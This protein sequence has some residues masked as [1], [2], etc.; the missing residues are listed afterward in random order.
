MKQE[1]IFS[2]VGVI[3]ILIG[4][5]LIGL[6]FFYIATYDKV[7]GIIDVRKSGPNNR[8]HARITYEYN[9]VLY[10]DIGLSSYN[11]FTMKDGK[12][13]SVY[14]N[15]EKPDWPKTTNFVFGIII[16]LFG[17]VITKCGGTEPKNKY[18]IGGEIK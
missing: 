10:E 1:R 17:I 7:D 4:L 8:I 13:C 18:S 14:I 2:W 9:D 16:L 12:K 5:F 11:A 6:S 15:P 3:C